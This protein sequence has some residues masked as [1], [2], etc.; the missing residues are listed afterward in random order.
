MADAGGGFEDAELRARR[1]GDRY[2]LVV[3]DLKHP[4]LTLR[5]EAVVI[6][7]GIYCTNDRQCGVMGVESGR[8]HSP[9][10]IGSEEPVELPAWARMRICAVRKSAAEDFRIAPASIPGEGML[11]FWGDRARFA[12]L[13]L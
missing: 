11:L 2:R 3:A 9:D 8:E 4:P 7:R 10:L 1:R 12:L 13:G 5:S 6:E